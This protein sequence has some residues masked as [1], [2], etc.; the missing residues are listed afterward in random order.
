MTP[1]AKPTTTLF[2]AAIRQARL[3]AR[4][5]QRTLASVLG[6][7]A[8]IVTMLER[9]Q[10]EPYPSIIEALADALDLDADELY[11]LA[12]RPPEDLRRAL[13]DL[14]NIKRV[15]ACLDLPYQPTR[16]ADV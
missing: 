6:V 13:A 4:L 5:S 16:T 15:R 8:A 10:K 11:S 1:N 7:N 3:D 12:G 9:G 14:E 2:G